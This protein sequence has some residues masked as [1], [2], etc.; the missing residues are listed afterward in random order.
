MVGQSLKAEVAVAM[1]GWGWVGVEGGG[2][3][4]GKGLRKSFG[5]VFPLFGKE[6]IFIFN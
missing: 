1:L 3:L 6:V 2:E 5:N 4:G